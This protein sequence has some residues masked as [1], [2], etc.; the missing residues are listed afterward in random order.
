[1]IYLDSAATTRMFDECI[2]EYKKF[3]CDIYYNPSALYSYSIAANTALKEARANLSKQLSCLSEEIYFV[4]SGSEADNIALLSTIKQKKGRVLISAVEH[5]AVF[6]TAMHLQDIGFEVITIPTDRFGRVD[7]M[8]YKKLLTK[9][10][11]LVSCIHVC[12]ETG[13]INPIDQISRLAKTVNPNCIVHSDGVQAFGKIPVNLKALNV[14]LYSISSHKIHGPKGVGVLFIKNTI[15]PRTFIFGGGQEKNIRSATENT[16]AIAA[17]NKAVSI[18]FNNFKQ[19]YEYAK[20]IQN[21]VINFIN[22]NLQDFIINT[23]I[24]NASPYIVSFSL[25]D[26]RG[27]GVVHYLEAKEIAIGTGSACSAKKGLKRIPLAL[28]LENEYHNGMLRISYDNFVTEEMVKTALIELK[29][30]IE[31]ERNVVKK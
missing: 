18:T 25:K 13:A 5:A 14:D 24:E 9:D 29:G 12:N 7:L 27:E 3:A 26:I 10:T 15:H 23:D 16:S 28:K 21:L 6:N 17:F 8:E 19:S 30:A 22:N 1:M 11:V 31:N 20:K 2:E 4:A